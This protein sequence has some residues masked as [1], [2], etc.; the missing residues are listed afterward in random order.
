[1][2]P[3][4]KTDLGHSQ[5]CDPFPAALPR[6]VHRAATRR[7]VSAARVCSSARPRR[8]RS[9]PA[10]RRHIGWLQTFAR[11]YVSCAALPTLPNAVNVNVDFDIASNV[12]F[13]IRSFEP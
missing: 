3:T 13:D 11:T 5:A 7:V 1:K 12:E 9:V 4:A 6:I 8:R 10:R 2:I